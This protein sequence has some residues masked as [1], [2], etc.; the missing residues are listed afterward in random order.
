MSLSKFE[1][2]YE[3][4]IEIK[5]LLQTSGLRFTGR[6]AYRDRGRNS[7][8]KITLEGIPELVVRTRRL[9][10]N[11][12]SPGRAR[13]LTRKFQIELAKLE[14]RPFNEMRSSLCS[15]PTLGPLRLSLLRS[16]FSPFCFFV[17]E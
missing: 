9:G 2:M 7:K 1:G 10:P 8:D 17:T 14:G 15:K 4:L 3:R 11:R 6:Y 12:D 16:Q 5:T 13:E